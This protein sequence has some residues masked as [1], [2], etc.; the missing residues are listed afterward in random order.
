MRRVPACLPG[1][2]RV[3]LNLEVLEERLPVSEALGA[4]L[5]VAA[6]A[7]AGAVVVRRD[8][9]PEAPGGR[10]VPG[11]TAP[12]QPALR[13]TAA[14]DYFAVGAGATPFTPLDGDEPF[15]WLA[16]EYLDP[17]A[18]E[19][20]PGRFGAGVTGGL[21]TSAGDLAGRL[22]GAFR[23]PAGPAATT[24]NP[25]RAVA[26]ETDAGA[27]AA[28]PQGP[29]ATLFRLASAEDATQTTWPAVSGHA[30]PASAVP[31]RP[32]TTSAR[33][34]APHPADPGPGPFDTLMFHGNAARTGW[35]SNETV[36]TPASVASSLGLVWQS[37]PLDSVTL[38]G[39][40]YPPHM[41]ATPLYADSVTITSGPYAGNTVGAV[42][43]ATSTGFVYAIKAFDTAGPTDIPP[44]TI[45]WKTSL[46]R[47]TPTIDGGVTVGVLSTPAIDLTANRIY[48]TS[49]V[50]DATG[51]NWDVFALD[52]GSG[53]VLPG[54]PL[55]I[56]GTTLAPINQNG[57][58]TWEG[59]AQESQRGALNLSPDGSL[60]YV[61]FGAYNDG[62]AGWMVAVDTQTPALAS[63][64][65]G[66]PTSVA[67]ANAGMWG[68]GGPAI[69]AAGN[70]MDTT[71]NSPSGSGSAPHVWGNSFLEW[72]PGTPLQLNGTYTP[73][74]YFQMDQNDTDLGGGSPVVIDLDPSTTGTP[75]L[76]AFGGKQ[77]N[78]YLVDRA[79]LRGSLTA[80]QAPSTD[81]STDTSL[82]PPGAQPQFG[83]PGPLNIFG[84][85]SEDSNQVD[86]AKS[87]TTPAYFQGADGTNYVVFSGSAK[88][89]V[90]STVPVAPSL[91]LTQIVTA[92]GQPAYL[93]VAAENTAPMTL[94]GA[95]VITSNG[96]SN[97]IAW[98]IDA[99]VKRTDSLAAPGAIHPTLYAYDALTMRPL[100]SSAH[101]ELDVA[102]KYYSPTVARGTVFVGTDRIQA[103][104]LTTDTIVDDS[105]QGTGV[106]QINYTGAWSHVDPTTVL[107]AFQGTV[108]IDST[109]N[110][111][112][113]IAFTGSQIK[114][115]STERNNRGIAAVSV[116]GGPETLVDM[117]SANDAG[118]ALVY[119]SPTLGPGGHTLTV[120]NTGTHNPGS[121]GTII[122]IDRINIT[123]G[124]GPTV[125]TVDDAVQ[126]TGPNQ[127]NY[128]GSW[129]HVTGTTIP[130]A[131]LGTVSITD[132][133]N[134]YAT[135]AFTGTRIKLYTG[136]RNN[137]GIAAVSIDGGP[138]TNVDMYAAID[139]GD[140][141][142]YTSPTLAPGAHAFK[143]RSTGTHDPSSTGTRICIDRFDIIA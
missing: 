40:V 1:D 103:F 50:T 112:A 119:T 127:V 47:P 35:N 24:A 41:Y 34:N 95:P 39:T 126:G 25:T 134:D 107:A 102:G 93:A 14:G 96:T 43:A 139:A 114:L 105:V 64:F 26:P 100:W 28:D 9:S 130:G 98:V 89:A 21:D 68:S 11:P 42:F 99:G 3:R 76:A 29:D 123:P 118:D 124:T 7:G 13:G 30:A 37:P 94:P 137:R 73:W 78:A 101:N 22:G 17:F 140:V 92:P 136:E 57:P 67:F 70:V 138:E 8:V 16:P 85:Y 135:I 4:A 66:A 38:G 77:G 91:A 104:G 46:G 125:T 143:V 27:P 141:L 129:S 133:T 84:P 80:R 56:N 44:G 52:L 59:A 48:L 97:P 6:L 31:A 120:R 109:T 128:V 54:W 82:L 83:K 5:T 49:D 19:S 69:D 53:A 72:N 23:A 15:S 117:Y 61:P 2:D 90:F 116:D 55:Q 122:C 32:P 33:A 36:L 65:A 18:A 71:G 121:S 113:A 88:A 63:A 79:N 142:V 108:S 111:T 132:V 110:D 131:Y 62:G 106:D 87:R 12:W 58:T 115:Y 10:K 51:R 86:Y 60:L 45:L 20:G 75:S 74:N 81:S